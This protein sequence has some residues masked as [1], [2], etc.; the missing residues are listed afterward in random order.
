VRDLGVI[1]GEENQQ[2]HEDRVGCLYVRIQ[3]LDRRTLNTSVIGSL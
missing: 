1:V 3:V 2:W